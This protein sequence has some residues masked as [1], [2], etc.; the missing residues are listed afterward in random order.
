VELLGSGPA[1]RIYKII[2]SFVSRRVPTP[3]SGSYFYALVAR[4]RIVGIARR[5]AAPSLLPPS[6]P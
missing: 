6:P 3:R 5:M 4:R 2:N 1:R